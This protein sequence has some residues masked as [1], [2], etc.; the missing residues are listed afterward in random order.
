M[1]LLIKEEILVEN[2]M[3]DNASMKPLTAPI[4]LLFLITLN[5]TLTP[6]QRVDSLWHWRPHVRRHN[7]SNGYFLF[8]SDDLT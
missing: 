3:Q 6:A 7:M 5:L 2:H 4:R 1:G 8:Q